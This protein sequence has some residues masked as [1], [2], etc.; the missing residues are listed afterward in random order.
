MA[1]IKE[2]AQQPQGHLP[3]DARP[4][5]DLLHI[6]ELSKMCKGSKKRELWLIQ[7]PRNVSFLPLLSAMLHWRGAA[8]CTACTPWSGPND[9]RAMP[10]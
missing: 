1:R 7:L 3:A 6:P 2:P 8:G 10:L 4:C 9:T 5:D